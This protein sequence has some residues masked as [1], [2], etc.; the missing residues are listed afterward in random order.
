M[1]L[2]AV[3]A[4]P[5][6]TQRSRDIIADNLAHADAFF[7]RWSDVFEWHRPQAGPIAFPR[8]KTGEDIEAWCEQVVAESGVLLLP[9]TAY[10]HACSIQ[11]GHFR[12]GFGRNNMQQCLQQLEGWLVKKYRT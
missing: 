12:M 6:L 2:A 11:R 8:L 9:A 4:T 3:R 10:E 5:Q 1:A 7:A